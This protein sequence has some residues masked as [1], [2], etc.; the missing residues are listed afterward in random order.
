MHISGRHLSR[1]FMSELGV[2]YSNYILDERIKKAVTLLKKSDL[3]LKEIAEETGFVS[4]QY[5]TRVFT[6]MMQISPGRFR[7]GFVDAQTTVFLAN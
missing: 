5:F 1:I 6:T 7:S 2:S 4:V 3:S